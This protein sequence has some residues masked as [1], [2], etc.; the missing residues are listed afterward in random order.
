MLNKRQYVRETAADEDGKRNGKD[1]GEP[2]RGWR[3]EARRLEFGTGKQRGAECI[4]AGVEGITAGSKEETCVKEEVKKRLGTLGA[5]RCARV[6][7]LRQKKGHGIGGRGDRDLG[8]PCKYFLHKL[9]GEADCPPNVIHGGN[10]FVNQLQ[11]CEEPVT[12]LPHSLDQKFG[13]NFGQGSGG[14]GN[15]TAIT[16]GLSRSEW[17]RG[18]AL[19]DALGSVSALSL[20]LSHSLSESEKVSENRVET[21][22]MPSNISLTHVHTEEIHSNNDTDYSSIQRPRV[23]WAGQRHAHSEGIH[24][25]SA[26]DYSSTKQAQRPRAPRVRGAGQVHVIHMLTHAE[27]IHHN[28]DIDCSRTQQAQS[29]L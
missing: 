14:C 17:G 24:S 27:G 13:Q 19:E 9:S 12:E 15:I 7:G 26:I 22:S 21:P 10:S 5:L 8:T 23:R 1:V 28:N 25:N 6:A 3:K 4:E 18:N 11:S 29:P 2:Q 16:G 20:S